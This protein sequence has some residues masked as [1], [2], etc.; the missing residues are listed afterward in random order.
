MEHTT[1]SWRN[2]STEVPGE[3]NSAGELNRF[4]FDYDDGEMGWRGEV[5]RRRRR[6]AA[7]EARTEGKSKHNKTNLYYAA[8]LEPCSLLITLVF[9]PGTANKK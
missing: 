1:E 3:H 6:R 7:R 4:K 5:A 9:N 2:I 8:S